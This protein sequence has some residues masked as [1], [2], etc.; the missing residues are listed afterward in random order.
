[1]SKP[2][3][4]LR[5]EERAL[6]SHVRAVLIARDDKMESWDVELLRVDSGA[7]LA[8]DLYSVPTPSRGSILDV[9]SYALS[10]IGLQ[11]GPSPLANA[12]QGPSDFT[13]P[14]SQVSHTEN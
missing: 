5:G 11:A 12:S 4:A 6:A 2:I 9:I 14:V 7:V 1:M 13:F 8:A 10:T 3:A